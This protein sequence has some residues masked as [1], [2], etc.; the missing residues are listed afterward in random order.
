MSVSFL[1]LQVSRLVAP[2]IIT[3]C[4]ALFGIFCLLQ[5]ELYSKYR[6][7]WGFFAGLSLG[8]GFLIKGQ[9]IFVPFIGLLPY[10]IWQNRRNE[11]LNNLMLYV[12]FVIGFLPIMIWFWLSWQHYGS[13]VFEQFF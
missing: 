8:L 2:D 12:G 4:I 10:L 3:I 11:H 13:I 9:L 1:W 7:Y 5:S 6:Y